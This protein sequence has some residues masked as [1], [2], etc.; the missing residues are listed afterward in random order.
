VVGGLD[1][2]RAADVFR[3]YAEN[4]HPGPLGGLNKG[5]Y[6]PA[7]GMA[8]AGHC[9]SHPDDAPLIQYVRPG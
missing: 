2:G 4:R 7:K 5:E 1:S 9:D 3:G 8:M 6:Q